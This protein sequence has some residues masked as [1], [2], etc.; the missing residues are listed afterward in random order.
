MKLITKNNTHYKEGWYV[1]K[2]MHDNEYVGYLEGGIFLEGS[3]ELLYGKP[4]ESDELKFKYLG[5][6]IFE[7]GEKYGEDS[8]QEAD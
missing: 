1:A 2:D 5:E 7:L 6:S 3:P 8:F 4:E